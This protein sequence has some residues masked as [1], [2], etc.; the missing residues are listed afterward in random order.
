M[1]PLRPGSRVLRQ[2]GRPG[3]LPWRLAG[4]GL[5]IG[6]VLA[7]GCE[8][9]GGDA[10]KHYRNALAAPSWEAAR[11]ECEALPPGENRED[12]LVGAMEALDRHERA[13]CDALSPGMWRDECIFLYAEREQ[14]AGDL[15]SAF[16]ACEETRFAREC[17]YHLI[18]TAAHA[19]V[20]A[21]IGEVAA[22][23][24]P[25]RVL[26][27]APD[28]PAL[29]WKAWVQ[30]RSKRGDTLDA[31]PCPDDLCRDAVREVLFQR[32]N[33]LFLADPATWC[34]VNDGGLPTAPKTGSGAVA[35]A[36]T[37]EMQELATRWLRG[38]CARWRDRGGRRPG[39]PQDIPAPP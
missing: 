25:Y 27:A 12:C 21:S 4:W 28:A 17:S 30:E 24:E 5:P 6:L 1:R 35:W 31:G 33:G 20:D 13:D 2:L 29:L 14:R 16:A 7:P 38:N 37:P 8:G 34:V 23:V 10:A 22:A 15:P 26:K 32:L 18:R 3:A 19:V 11:G 39:P 9:D 36:D